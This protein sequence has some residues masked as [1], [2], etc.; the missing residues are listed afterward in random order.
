MQKHTKMVLE[1]LNEYL[2]QI[3]SVTEKFAN[4]FHIYEREHIIENE[5]INSILK[6]ISDKAPRF[7]PRREDKETWPG[8]VASEEML[9]SAILAKKEISKLPEAILEGSK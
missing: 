3:D 4:D 9:L 1:L 7:S 8:Y 6:E 5:K 2:M